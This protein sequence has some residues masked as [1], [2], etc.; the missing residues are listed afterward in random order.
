MKSNFLIYTISNLLILSLISCKKYED[1]NFNKN[2]FQQ[3]IAIPIGN[4]TYDINDMFVAKDSNNL[5]YIDPA[6]NQLALLYTNNLSTVYAKD[7]IILNQ[8]NEQT[9]TTFSD[10]N[11]IP[12]NNFNNTLNVSSNLNLNFK[13]S[14]NEE[15]NLIKFKSGKLILNID[16][17]VKHDLNLLL[18]FKGFIKN[19]LEITKDIS[20]PYTGQAITSTQTEIDLSDVQATFTNNRAIIQMDIELIGNGNEILGNEFIKTDVTSQ[21]LSFKEIYGFFGQDPIANFRDSVLFE[22][23]KNNHQGQITF[24]NPS[25]NFEVENEFGFPVDISF[26]N[27]EVVD[28]VSNSVIPI[29]N[30]TTKINVA[31]AP[32]LNSSTKSNM[33]LNNS[34]TTNLH[35]LASSIPQ[36]LYYN[37]NALPNPLGKTNTFNFASE[38]SKLKLNTLVNLPFE[39]YAYGIILEDTIKFEDFEESNLENIESVQLKLITENGFPMKLTTILKV[40]DENYNLLF[41]VNDVP[42]VIV[43]NAPIN[44]SGKVIS[45]VKKTSEFDITNE[46]IQLL[47]RAKKIIIHSEA[48]T[49]NYD[50]NTV[51][52]IYNDYK[53]NMDLGIQIQRK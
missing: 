12:V 46:Q 31:S 29:I 50:Q 47:K 32:N 30:N 27:L 23:F 53:I 48:S 44:S 51:V 49:N 20:V 26:N 18:T 13:G 36:Y 21:D 45:S 24:T 43:E 42:K 1:F 17:D 38:N 2:T 4:N 34:N 6:S 25:I 5:I 16:T 10:L 52:K 3:N 22:L 39:G 19:S 40:V 7:L 15:I 8:I 14:K 11:I 35:R 28:A 41:L 9:T 33:L 37:A